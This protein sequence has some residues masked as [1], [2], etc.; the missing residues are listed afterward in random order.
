MKGTRFTTGF[1]KTLKRLLGCGVGVHHAG[2]LPRY[3]L[4]VER[5]AQQG[6]SA[7]DLR[8][9]YA[10][11]GHQRPDSHGPAHRAGEI[12]RPQAAP[13]AGARV[14][15]DSGPGRPRR[16]R[17]R[18]FGDR[19]GAR[20]RHRERARWQRRRAIRKQRKIKKKKPPEG[21]VGWSEQTFNRLVSAEPRGAR[22]PY[23]HDALHGAGAGG[24]RRRRLGARGRA[25]GHRLRPNARAEGAPSAARFRDIRN[26]DGHRRGGK[27]GGG[28]GRRRIR[29]DGRPARRFCA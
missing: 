4:L 9:R 1:G 24:A 2:M 17:Y 15:S 28:G 11:S 13:S 10:R 21:F 8:Y 23:A 18:G 16:L 20:A 26:A 25:G 5:L 29:A 27:D 19:R 14:P 6:P 3:R 12:R 7:G 22:A